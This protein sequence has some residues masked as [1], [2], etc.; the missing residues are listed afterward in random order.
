MCAPRFDADREMADIVIG[1]QTMDMGCGSLSVDGQFDGGRG[2]FPFPIDDGSV[3]FD[4]MMSL[5]NLDDRFM[6]F[7]GFRHEQ[8]TGGVT[9]KT[10]GGLDRW[11]T[12]LGAD[13]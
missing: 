13:D 6:R 10:V 11:N 2:G 3:D 5:K 7:L 9:V 1:T 4:H 8:T 12:F